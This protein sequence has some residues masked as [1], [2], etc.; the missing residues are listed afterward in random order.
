MSKQKKKRGQ[1]KRHK[2]GIMG[3]S[4]IPF[5]QR[6]NIQQGNDIAVGRNHAAKITMF[7]DCVALNELE[8]IGYKRLVRYS[9]RFKEIVDEFYAD[10]ELGMAHAKRR[11]E[12]MGRPISGDLYRVVVPGLSPREQEI[13]DN[14]LQA[15][16]I[17]LICSAI[18]KNDEFGLGQERQERIALRSK[19]LSARYA[20]EGEQFLLDKLEKIGFEIVDG[21]A[22]CYMAD[23]GS[24]VTPKQFRKEI[25]N[26]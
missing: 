13:H 3:R 5:A 21:E 8:G 18:A 26:G 10:V 9:L 20:K 2:Q 24:I 22:R 19:E 11:M 14:A 6:I 16:Q 23:D 7:C 12:Q 1:H 25:G 4:D 17:A 15:A